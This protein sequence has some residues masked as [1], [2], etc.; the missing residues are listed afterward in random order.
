MVGTSRPHR[1]HDDAAAHLHPVVLGVVPDQPAST[2]L[3]AAGLAAALGT[4]LVCVW[5]DGS[6]VVVAEQPDGA[7]TTTPLDPDEDDDGRPPEAE[8]EV[9]RHLKSV[10]ADVRHPWL[11]VSTVG[12]TVRGLTAA[13]EQHD[14]RRIAVG[15]RRSGIAGWMNQLVGGSVA[16]RLAHTQ[17]RPVV[18]LPHPPR[19]S[20]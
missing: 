10:L 17:G 14:A 12:E 5:V 20:A 1:W 19:G 13:A 18:V 6:R 11:F 8:Q 9:D 3:Q 4:G 16:G 2:V 15:A 7:L